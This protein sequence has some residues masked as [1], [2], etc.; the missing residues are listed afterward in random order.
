LAPLQGGKW[1]QEMAFPVE[2]AVLADAL[3]L[4]RL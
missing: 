4:R 1:S 3:E 2:Y